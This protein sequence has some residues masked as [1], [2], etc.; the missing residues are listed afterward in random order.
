MFHFDGDRK[1]TG[2]TLIELL[3]VIGVISLLVGILLPALGSARRRSLQVT[4]NGHMRDIHNAMNIHG[5]S[6]EGRLPGLTAG[7]DLADIEGS[8]TGAHP[9]ARYELMLYRNYFK[10]QHIVAPSDIHAEPATGV[11][12]NGVQEVATSNYSYAMLEI[13]DDASERASSWATGAPSR[14]PMLSDRAEPAGS[15]PGSIWG[16]EWRGGVVY[17]DNHVELL[18]SHVVANTRYSNDVN[19]TDDLFHSGGAGTDAHM[20]HENATTP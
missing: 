18:D 19:A 12:K 6:N 2:F 14:A 4:S 16:P 11:T 9:A 3:V 1:P 10:P 13:S 17:G 8:D 5:N 7:Q 20:V 15:P